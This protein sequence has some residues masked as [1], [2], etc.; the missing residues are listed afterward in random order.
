MVH[1]KPESMTATSLPFITLLPGLGNSNN[2]VTF[3]ALRFSAASWRF[4]ISELVAVATAVAF[5]RFSATSGFVSGTVAARSFCFQQELLLL[6]S[7]FSATVAS[8][9]LLLSH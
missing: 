4:V 9:Q 5:Y 6:H 2:F 7:F 8:L 1:I 3:D